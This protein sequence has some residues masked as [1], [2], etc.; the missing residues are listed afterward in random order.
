MNPPEMMR[1]LFHSVLASLLLVAA[2]SS[3][4]SSTS[5]SLST[6]SSPSTS[7]SPVVTGI[8]REVEVNWSPADRVDPEALSEIESG[9]RGQGVWTLFPSDFDPIV[10]LELSAGFWLLR[11]FPTDL[12]TAGLFLRDAAG[13]VVFSVESN[14]PRLQPPCGDR[15]SDYP[16]VTVRGV[17]GCAV[18]NDR[19]FTVIEWEEG[20][21]MFQAGSELDLDEAV[22]WLTRWHRIPEGCT[23]TVANGRCPSGR[24]PDRGFGVSR[25]RPALG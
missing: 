14:D 12:V 15:R 8:T 4:S 23:P 22:D 2:C 9:L 21:R 25:Q 3:S 16:P 1:P 6:S 10:G 5:S 19:G 11:T 20:D 24:N 17:S 18:T 7:L 13:Q